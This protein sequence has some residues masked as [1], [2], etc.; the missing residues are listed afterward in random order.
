MS[1]RTGRRGTVARHGRSLLVGSL[2]RDLAGRDLP[3]VVGQGVGAYP[4]RI[5]DGSGGTWLGSDVPVKSLWILA[6]DT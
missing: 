1:G 2:P 4:V 6:R 5:V 3:A